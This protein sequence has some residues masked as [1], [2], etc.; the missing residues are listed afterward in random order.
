MSTRFSAKSLDNSIVM[1]VLGVSLAVAMIG[2]GV[3]FYKTN[4]AASVDEIYLSNV[5]QLRLLTQQITQH[6][7]RAANGKEASFDSIQKQRANFKNTLKIIKEGDSESGLPTVPEEAA[8]ALNKVETVWATTNESV[9]LLSKTREAVISLY[10]RFDELTDLTTDI[11]ANTEGMLDNMIAG[12]AD[13]AQMFIA[14]RQLMILE[15]IGNN[16]RRSFQGDDGAINAEGQLG[17]DITTFNDAT[18]TLLNGNDEL[19]IAAVDDGAAQQALLNLQEL[20]NE[21]TQSIEEFLDNS[22][23][24]FQAKDSSFDIFENNPNLLGNIEVLYNAYNESI[25]QR[26]YSNSLGNIL[27]IVTVVLLIVLFVVMIISGKER[28]H[29]TRS[30]LKESQETNTRNQEAILRLLSEISDL[31]DGD[32]TVTATVTEDFTGAISDALNY[33]IE[34]LRDLVISI[35]KTAF[36]VTTAA[37]GTRSTATQLIQASDRQA[38]Q[39]AKAGQAILGMANSVKKVS[40]NAIESTDVA[41]KSVDIAAKGANAVQDTITGMDTIR[42]QI[43]ETSKRIKRLGESS[44]EIGEIVSLID[45]IA[46]QTNILA[47]NAAIQAAMA[48]EAGR[49]FAV[50]ADEIQRLAERSGNATKQIDTLV[51]TIQSDTNEAVSSMEQST[52]N[53]VSGARLAETAGGAL[54]EIENVSVQLAEQI[55]NISQTS[56][57]QAAVASNISG[58]VSIIQEITTQT[59]RGTNETAS[60]IEHLAELANDLKT[61]VSGF[62]LPEDVEES[63]ADMGSD[64]L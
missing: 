10:G 50:V 28:A 4:Q 39:I 41:K 46:D 40:A 59:L 34:A 33:S 22:E 26:L 55:E 5:T 25:E 37:Q 1:I 36:Q 31:A 27:A 57:T 53:V 15:R 43:Q 51:K 30:R 35:N 2:T 11:V 52:A 38:Q 54:T 48:G 19:N 20:F 29:E 32:L 21:R 14:T 16:I 63:F 60:S 7:A 62:T 47:L 61:S 9:N 6:A 8:E 18:E 17:E 45:D 58:T 42:E 24:L 44:Q 56:R 3:V 64:D 23:Q 12:D 49:G 13:Q